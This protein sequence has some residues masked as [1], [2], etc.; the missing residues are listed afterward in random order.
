MYDSK[1]APLAYSCAFILPIAYIIGL[2]FTMRTHSSE[3][4]E[5]FETQ[6]KEEIGKAAGN[7][8]NNI[9]FFAEMF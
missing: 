4:Y 5:E 6:L 8:F 1:V 3:I 7:K 9:V 2:I